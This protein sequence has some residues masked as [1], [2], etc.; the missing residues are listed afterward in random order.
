MSKLLANPQSRRSNRISERHLNTD[1]EAIKKFKK[2]EP[3][4]DFPMPKYRNRKNELKSKKDS[5][6]TLAETDST[7]DGNM[8]P[9]KRRGRKRSSNKMF[10]KNAY[11][12][13]DKIKDELNEGINNG[14]LP[15]ER[16]KLKHQISA[17]NAR[18]RNKME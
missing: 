4:F 17:Q 18:I 15:N 1:N 11:N 5:S 6:T 14:I 3:V 12:K 10:I 9:L 2:I 13:I 16:S 8:I 7:R